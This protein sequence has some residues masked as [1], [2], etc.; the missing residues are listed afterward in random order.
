MKKKN[1]TKMKLSD[2]NRTLQEA[3]STL[4]SAPGITEIKQIELYTK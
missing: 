4:E 3:F 1:S 2:W